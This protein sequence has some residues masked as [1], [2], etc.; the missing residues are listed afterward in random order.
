M[1]ITYSASFGYNCLLG[2]DVGSPVYA[3]IHKPG[4]FAVFVA[5]LLV[6]RRWKY[7]WQ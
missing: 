6:K 5:I 4:A 3:L 7:K 1:K 2:I